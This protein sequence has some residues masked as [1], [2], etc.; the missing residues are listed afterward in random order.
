MLYIHA[1]LASEGLA[2]FH[3]LSVADPYFVLPL[4]PCISNL[5]VIELHGILK[6]NLLITY[7]L[8]SISL[9]VLS[10]ASQLP[11]SVVFYWAVSC[12]Y[13]LVLGLVIKTPILNK[14]FDPSKCSLKPYPD[15]EV[16]K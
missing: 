3:D 8:R 14:Y 9:L 13:G 16:R 12:V 11:S 4:I 10:I 1:E 2:W 7:F 6:V 15:P 5:L